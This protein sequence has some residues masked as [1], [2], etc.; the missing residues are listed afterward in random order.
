MNEQ[1]LLQAFSRVDRGFV[2]EAEQPVTRN[3]PVLLRVTASLAAVAAACAGIYFGMRWLG[4]QQGITYAPG[5]SDNLIESAVSDTQTDSTSADT[6]GTQT[7]VTTVSQ[8]E[9][10][11]EA[12]VTEQT[13]GSAAE[14]AGTTGQTTNTTAKQTTQTT[15]KQ[16]TA[17]QTTAKQMTAKTTGT[18]QRTTESTV[19]TAQPPAQ[20][21]P[22][23]VI[24]QLKTGYLHGFDWD[25]ERVFRSGEAEAHLPCEIDCVPYGVAFLCRDSDLEALKAGMIGQYPVNW[26]EGAWTDAGGSGIGYV[27]GA[28]A[29]N[30]LVQPVSGFVYQYG[31]D[32]AM[33]MSGT[34]HSFSFRYDQQTQCRVMNDFSG[35]AREGWTV[36]MAS[37]QAPICCTPGGA[38]YR[39]YTELIRALAEKPET[40]L[41]DIVYGEECSFGLP[42]PIIDEIYEFYVHIPDG[43]AVPGALSAYG[44]VDE[45]SGIPGDSYWLLETHNDFSSAY[46]WYGLELSDDAVQRFLSP[47]S[48]E[49]LQQLCEELEAIP[50]V[51]LAQPVMEY[52]A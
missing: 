38:V 13:T 3:S 10:T 22:E 34:G 33:E 1:E 40:V 7:T 18:T 23:A 29:D 36:C 11:T 50:G 46:G 9:Q 39:D 47:A 15:A 48:N 14:T 19:T 30:C 4:R 28:S 31:G 12:A 44:T 16:T 20:A 8:T 41:L 5:Y 37:V 49:G 6:T 32:N 25:A 52:Y 24:Q 42:E 27:N 2:E 35:Y 45:M 26:S 21:D 43:A 17:K 51:R